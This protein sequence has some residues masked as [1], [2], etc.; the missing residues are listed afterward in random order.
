MQIRDLE[1]AKTDERYA[2]YLGSFSY[3]AWKSDYESNIPLAPCA[4]W[5]RKSHLTEAQVTC[6]FLKVLSYETTFD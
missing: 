2:P 6:L 3:K 4:F 1:K 5:T